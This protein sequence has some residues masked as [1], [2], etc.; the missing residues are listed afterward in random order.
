MEIACSKTM[1]GSKLTHDTGL[2]KRIFGGEAA[3]RR[4]FFRRR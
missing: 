4:G 2:V 1:I 3:F